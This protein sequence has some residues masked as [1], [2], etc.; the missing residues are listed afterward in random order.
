MA[1]VTNID[2]VANNNSLRARFVRFYADEAIEKGMVVALS[3]ADTEPDQGYGNH[4]LMAD[5]DD[6]RNQHGI[7]IATDAIT[8]GSVGKVQVAGVCTIAQVT[9]ALSDSDEGKML[10]ASATEGELALTDENG[11]D[12]S[13][14]LTPVAILIEYGTA[15]TADS[16]VYLLN[17]L[18]L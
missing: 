14:F 13:G 8:S 9:T 18:N 1:T 10:A 3:M 2:G 5:T 11:A 4:I 6:A 7:G 15:A 12:G 17:P 16:T